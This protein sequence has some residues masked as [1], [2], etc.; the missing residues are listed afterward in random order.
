[1]GWESSDVVRFDLW[2]PLQGQMRMAKLKSAYNLFIVVPRLS[3]CETNLKVITGWETSD[4]VRSVLEFWDV[5]LVYSK[6]WAGSFLM[7][8]DFTLGPKLESAYNSLTIVPR[9]LGCEG[10]L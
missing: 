5:K 2:S 10:N 9:V 7:R 1:M 8:S 6:S 4:V 3:G